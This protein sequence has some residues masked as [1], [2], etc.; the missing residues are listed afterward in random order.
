MPGMQDRNSAEGLT[1]IGMEF[2]FAKR[3][4]VREIY[5]D[6]VERRKF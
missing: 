2:C 1:V 6:A 5:L 3:L 4:S